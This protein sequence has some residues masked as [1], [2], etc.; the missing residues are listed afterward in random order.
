MSETTI[1]VSVLT[2][3]ALGDDPAAAGGKAL[4]LGVLARGGFPVPPGFCVTTAAYEQVTGDPGVRAA[5]DALIAAAPGGDERPALAASVRDALTA[6]PVPGPLAAAIT[7]AYRG[8]GEPP[9]AVRSSATAEDLPY[10]SFAGQ[11]DTYL[12]VTGAEAVLDAVR[13]CW[14]SLWTDR[15][16]AYRD[17]NCVDHRSVRLAVVVQ[18]MVESAVAG[19]L[20][21]ADPLTGR[22]GRA[23]VDAAPGLGEAVVSGLV[24]PDHFAVD[25]RTG[26]V[27]ERVPGDKRVRIGSSARGGT[28]RVDGAA[29]PR[30][31]LTD[32]QLAA[33]ARAGR[34]VEEHYGAPQDIE[35][36]F[37]AAGA[38]W[39]TQARPITTLYPLP[40]DAPAPDDP[41][42]RVYWSANVAQGVMGPLTP[43]GLAVFRLVAADLAGLFGI[44]VPD[45]YAGPPALKIAGER[46][47]LDATAAVRSRLGRMVVPKVLGAME[48]RSAPL[49]HELFDD[50]R[51]SVRYRSPWPVVRHVGPALLR[52][53]APARI[54]AALRRPASV[55]ARMEAV[56]RDNRAATVVPDGTPARRRLDVAESA[57]ARRVT[58]TLPGAL[59]GLIVPAVLAQA[60]A[61]RALRGVAS[62]E[63]FQAVLRGLPHNP[64]TRMD[65]DLWR[66]AVSLGADPAARDLF[67]GTTAAELSRRYVAG[68]PLPGGIRKE[69]DGFL[70]AY[71]HRGV[72]EIDVGVPRWS[73]DPAHIFNVLAGYL[74]LDDPGL[75][76]ETVFARAAADAEAMAATLTERARRRGRLRGAATGFLLGRLRQLMGLRERPK[77]NLVA[78]LAG[79]RAQLA[80]VGA[81]LARGGVLDAADDV[82]FVDFQEAREGLD[83]RDLRPLVRERRERYASEGRRRH[84]PRVLLSDGTEPEAVA[85]AA[86]AAGA[87]GA[88]ADGDAVLTGSPASAGTVT[89]PV[90]V[91]LDPG[92]ARLEPGEILVAPSTDPGWTPLFL[93]A[94]GLIMEMGGAMSHGAVV[95]REYGIPAVVGVPNATTR[96][97]TGTRLTLNG[98]TG[99]ATPTR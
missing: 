82:F 33:L 78:L 53:R 13:R 5:V 31:C 27:L 16:V 44:D 50:P 8:L 74:R 60:L 24:N 58:P 55:R 70:A 48:A 54:A 75:A 97:K 92:D 25:A 4:N 21:T 41:A 57:L 93:T 23:V 87:G 39:L 34:R 52:L 38:L 43:M 99:T 15:A 29:D 49:V 69:M 80:A 28:E 83:G 89:A 11:Q 81:E 85:E 62:P 91:V 3:D 26:D 73:D 59:V 46:L 79:V 77:F 96:L 9:V 10:A 47:F 68:E 71:G 17:A 67:A 1:G 51:L 98:T 18:E 95:A 12:G 22:R 63:E 65:L 76:P 42:P 40:D 94:G 56:E 90:R 30:P 32:E 19:V 66:A 61:R 36:A 7:A 45:R 35:W 84:V 72:A 86:R 6:A 20:F 14:A 37:D 2:L 88:D 64:T